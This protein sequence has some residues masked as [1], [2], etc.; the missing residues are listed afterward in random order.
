MV[1]QR[2]EPETKTMISPRITYDPQANALYMRFSDNDIAATLELSES[3]YV[4]VDTDGVP[5]GLEVLD[6][7]SNLMTGLPS[8]PDSTALKDLMTRDA[9]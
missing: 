5:V 7:S 1:I 2:G 9:A 4:D 3:V 8:V 6:A